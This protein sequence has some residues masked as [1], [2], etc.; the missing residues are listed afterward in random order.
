MKEKARKISNITAITMIVFTILSLI[1]FFAFRRMMEPDQ[2]SMY[3]VSVSDYFV[4]I[5][6]VFFLFLILANRSG[7]SQEKIKPKLNTIETVVL[8]LAGISFLILLSG[9]YEIFLNGPTANIP[10]DKNMGPSEHII[11]IIL[12]VLVPAIFDE[13]IFRGL[14]ANGYSIFGTTSMFV[15]SSLVYSL[16]KFSLVEFPLLFICGLVFCLVYY[17]TGSTI[18]SMIMH[19]IY[20]TIAYVIKYLKVSYENTMF[21]NISKTIYIIMGTIFVITLVLIIIKRRKIDD[22]EDDDHVLTERF[23]TPLMLV[24]ISLAVG[25]TFVEYFVF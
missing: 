16:S 3:I 20:S 11:V 12:Y 15:L 7:I 18:F 5:L 2:I 14:F 17:M 13:L 9:I 23:F 21:T 19:L 22:S 25:T 4:K 24:F 1:T 8:M 6:V 10:V